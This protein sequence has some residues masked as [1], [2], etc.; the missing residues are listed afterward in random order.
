MI[1]VD[2]DILVVAGAD[3]CAS[4][5]VRLDDLRLCAGTFGENVLAMGP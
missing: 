5:R 3:F 2:A 4:A 1:V